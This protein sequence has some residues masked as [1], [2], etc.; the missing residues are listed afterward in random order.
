MFTVLKGRK[1]L[2]KEKALLPLRTN[3]E[4]IPNLNSVDVLFSEI[5]ESSPVEGMMGHKGVGRSSVGQ[6]HSERPLPKVR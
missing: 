2:K 1:K 5:K 6:Q 4:Q 3:K